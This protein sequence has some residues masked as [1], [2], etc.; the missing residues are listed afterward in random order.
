MK[1]HGTLPEEMVM[2]HRAWRPCRSGHNPRHGWFAVAP[3][4]GLKNRD[5]TLRRPVSSTFRQQQI[6]AA[7]VD[8]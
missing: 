4:M 7:E 3:T 1:G 5:V 2:R 8:R 6:V